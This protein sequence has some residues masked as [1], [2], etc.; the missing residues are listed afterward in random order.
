MTGFSGRLHNHNT[1]IQSVLSTWH[2]VL[3]AGR[4][5]IFDHTSRNY[6]NV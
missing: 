3:Y 2:V 4:M 5:Y 6:E 1:N